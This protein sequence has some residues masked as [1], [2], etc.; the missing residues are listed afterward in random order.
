MGWLGNRREFLKTAG[1]A[2]ATIPFLRL[3]SESNAQAQK[4]GYEVFREGSPFDQKFAPVNALNGKQISRATIDGYVAAINSLRTGSVTEIDI[5]GVTYTDP[6]QAM[7]S[8]SGSKFLKVSAAPAGG[9]AEFYNSLVPDLDVVVSF[10]GSQTGSGY[11]GFAV[12]PGALANIVFANRADVPLAV[13]GYDKHPDDDKKIETLRKAGQGVF[14][15]RYKFVDHFIAC[16]QE[17][18]NAALHSDKYQALANGN[19]VYAVFQLVLDNSSVHYNMLKAATGISSPDHADLVAL[20]N[21]ENFSGNPTAKVLVNDIDEYVKLFLS[22]EQISVS[23]KAVDPKLK[24]V[25]RKLN[26]LPYKKI[27]NLET[28]LIPPAAA[29]DTVSDSGI[30]VVTGG[31]LYSSTKDGP[32]TFGGRD[33]SS[34]DLNPLYIPAA[35]FQQYTG[36]LAALRGDAAAFSAGLKVSSEKA[37][38]ADYTIEQL[39]FMDGLFKFLRKEG[40]FSLSDAFRDTHPDNLRSQYSFWVRCLCRGSYPGIFEP[41][42]VNVRYQN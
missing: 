34:K 16:M 4:A 11:N 27:S 35:K 31:R 20:I 21:Q 39:A 28:Y 9:V 42:S 33:P 41:G 3:F 25:I 12:L 24:E 14:W 40:A 26:G 22:G 37:K 29:N 5:G 10:F 32:D 38:I 1:S 8:L 18:A 36:L 19:P 23:A 30:V 17:G 7:A 15:G 6:N 2:G 13:L